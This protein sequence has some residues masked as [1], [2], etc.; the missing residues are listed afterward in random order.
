MMSK[1]K[2][3][4]ISVC[5]MCSGGCEEAT[6]AGDQDAAT[7]GEDPELPPKKPKGRRVSAATR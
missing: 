3:W 6:D 5:A 2:S 7:G 1:L 4:K